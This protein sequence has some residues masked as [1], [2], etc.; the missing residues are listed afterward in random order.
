[1]VPRQFVPLAAAI[2]PAQLPAVRDQWHLRLDV[3]VT[4]VR[5]WH[6][7]AAA[8]VPPLLWLA[9]HGRRAWVSRRRRRLG[10]CRRCGYDL[11]GSESGRC[12]ECGAAA[13]MNGATA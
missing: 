1:V 11:R 13:A 7:V 6:V 10:L 3:S 12:S 5:H 4:S 9:V 2:D 8:A